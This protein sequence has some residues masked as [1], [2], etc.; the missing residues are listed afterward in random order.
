MA[1]QS[2]F[3]TDLSPKAFK[4]GLN[5]WSIGDGTPGSQTYDAVDSAAFVPS[6]G[7]FDGCLELQKIHATQKL[8][9]TTRT[10]V[11]K[12]TYIRV[13]T[14]LKC[15]T[16]N[17][18]AARIAA[19]AIR[20]NGSHVSEVT[21]FGSSTAIKKHG[22]IYEISAIIGPGLR[23]GVDMVWGSEP[24]Y[25][26]FGLDLTGAN[27]GI[28]RIDDFEIE[29][30]THL[31]H[32]DTFNVVD[33]RDY[34]GVG[35]GTTD[36]YNAFVNA[37]RAADGRVLLVPQGTYYVGQG[38]SLASPVQFR[39][40]LSMPDHAPLV[41]NH[42]YSIQPYLDAF[43]DGELALKKALQALMN[44][45]AHESLDLC[46]KS[47]SIRE[48]LN[49]HATMATANDFLQ[50]RVVRNGK[51]YVAGDE[52]WE[53]DVVQSRATYSLAFQ[54]KLTAVSKISSIRVG[55]LVEGQGV[56]REVYVT[57]VN[58]SRK[59]IT[60]SA[61]LHDA[62][63]TQNFTFTRF[64][65][66]IDFSGFTRVSK[67]VFQNIEFQCD[68]K[69]SGIMLAPSGYLFHAK[70][71]FFNRPKNR[72]ITSI[73]TGCQGMLVDQ[74]KF[75]S[76]E[77][78]E[79]AQD[80]ITVALNVNA[81]D[82]KLRE[83]WC[84][85][86]R[87]FAIL[88]GSN[89]LV[90][91]NHFYQ[92]DGEPNGIRT[93]GIALTKPNTAST[94][95]GNYIDNCFIEWTNEHEPDPIYSSGFGFSALSISDNVFLSGNVAPWFAY[96]VVKPFGERHGVSHLTVNN[97][98]F[99]SINGAIDRVER[100]DTTFADIDRTKL[101]NIQFLGNN[102]NNVSDV[103][104]NPA[105]VHHSQNSRSSVWNVNVAD[106]LPFG[107]F[108]QYVDSIVAHGPIQ[109][110]SGAPRYTMPYTETEKGSSK[111]QVNLRWSESVRGK[112]RITVR[113]DT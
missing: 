26:H 112:V 78:G 61:P 25:G 64:K 49:V 53:N 43:N 27:G 72:G 73:G 89:N 71:C 62:E 59:E 10:P 1:V 47:I 40:T 44:G 50:R 20:S 24:D 111:G 94:I 8:R 91:G 57:S 107:G 109:N 35:D 14:R 13:R 32:P 98:N 65:Y 38:L 77:G 96:I 76:S 12:E 29:D 106:Y 9:Y 108:A 95:V 51:I 104:E 102:F 41:L 87:S 100:I 39:G 81:N 60:L 37:D 21:Q 19:Y 92:G 33:L 69:A 31:F 46:G 55:S 99:R 5:H 45:G 67:F 42:F 63:G 7:Q 101:R 66:L 48:P 97:N 70:D 23:D 58:I 79:K 28:I 83:N 56:G 16:G 74:C 90:S 105:L 85:Y 17:L 75:Q 82:A 18:P 22:R 34:G 88:S 80:R 54:S 110:S 6:D 15:V 93:A 11:Q 36:N 86:F 3:G 52:A 103:T 84:S 2:A 4:D 113:C 30:V 68:S